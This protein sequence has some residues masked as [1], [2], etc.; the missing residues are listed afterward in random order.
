M[1]KYT[2]SLELSKKLKELGVKQ[3]SEFYHS[4]RYDDAI[5]MKC[6]FDNFDNMDKEYSAFLTGEL[7]EML[8]RGCRLIKDYKH[9][10][11]FVDSYQTNP[12][13]DKKNN[14]VEDKTSAN[15]TAK[16]LIYLIENKLMEL[17]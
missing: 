2:I 13:L 10:Y 9:Y 15:A 6:Y 8:P 11:V 12:F 17:K 16:L 4:G 3:D 14:K 5:V 7:F 1:E